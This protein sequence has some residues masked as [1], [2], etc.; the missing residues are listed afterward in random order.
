MTTKVVVINTYI[1]YYYYDSGHMGVTSA[2]TKLDCR[3]KKGR[4]RVSAASLIENER[5]YLMDSKRTRLSMNWSCTLPVG[6]VRCLA[7]IIS[8]MFLG[9]SSP[10]CIWAHSSSVV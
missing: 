6:P 2:G 10:G 5:D 9:Y 7:M 3:K 4:R 1:Y 8:A